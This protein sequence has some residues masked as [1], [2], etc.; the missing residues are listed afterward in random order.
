MAPPAPPPRPTHH[1]T[2]DV[3]EYFQVVAL[4]QVVRRS[5][6]DRMASRVERE[7][8]ALLQLLDAASARATCFTLGW[9]AQHQP[10]LVRRLAAAGHEIA[11]HGWDHVRVTHQSPAEFRKSVR[12]SKAAL[13]ELTGRPV[14]GF[15]AP[16]F[17]IVPGLEWAFDILLEE[18]YRYDS[19]LFPIRRPGGYGYESAQ[20]DPHHL[21]R[22]AGSLVEFPLTTLRVA[23]LNLPAAGGGYFRLLPYALVRAGFRSCERRGVPGTFYVHPWELDAEQPR[24]PVAIPTRLRHYGGLARTHGRLARLL[25]EFSFRPIRETLREIDARGGRA[26]ARAMPLTLVSTSQ[27]ARVGA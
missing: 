12:D 13:E 24:L 27:S 14:L 4:E 21:E 22:P 16:S 17:S 19:S 15:R 6:W 26:P 5:W 1:F 10:Q 9:V 3:E 18:G 11:S 20:R 2:I 8:D 25:G 23:G 7:M